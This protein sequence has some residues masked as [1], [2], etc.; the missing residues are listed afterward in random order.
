MPAKRSQRSRTMS[1]TEFKAQCLS[2]MDDVQRTGDEVIITKHGKA[3][4]RL[5][6]PENALSS[7]YG[8]MNGTVTFVG[9]AT[10]PEDVW[11]LDAS[12]FPKR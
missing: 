7:A 9:D 6:A 4:A 5:V 8:W 10:A 1:A 11:D 12:I 3:V 2:L